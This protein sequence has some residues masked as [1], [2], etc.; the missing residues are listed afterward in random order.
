MIITCEACSTKFNLDESLLKPSGSKVRCSKCKTVFTAYPPEPEE[1]QVL[2]EVE[3]DPE[4]TSDDD[5]DFSDLEQ[6]LGSD[7]SSSDDLEPRD[8]SGIETTEIDDDIDEEID[9]PGLEDML[10]S[11]EDYQAPSDGDQDLELSFDSDEEEAVSE[12]DD[13]DISFD[14]D[15]SVETDELE[16]E[17]D[18]DDDLALSMDSDDAGEEE[19]VDDDL[20]DLS[21]SLDDADEEAEFID[22]ELEDFD[23]DLSLEPDDADEAEVADITDEELEDFDLD[24]SLEP[25]DTDEAEVADV[26]D[27]SL[28]DLDLDL[29]GV[30]AE[31]TLESDLLSTKTVSEIENDSDDLDFELDIDED[32]DDEDVEEID[33]AELEQTL[34]MEL[35]SPVDDDDSGGEP[36][37][38]DLELADDEDI[39]EDIDEE[40][41]MADDADVSDIEQMLE[42]DLDEEPDGNADEIEL[43]F[44]IDGEETEKEPA[45]ASAGDHDD[46]QSS[47]KTVAEAKPDKT[48]L[49]SGLDTKP[50]VKKKLST[51]LVILIVLL[52][53]GVAA[54]GGYFLLI[55][56]GVKLPSLQELNIPYISDL[57]NPD[58]KKDLG[59]V[60]A[61]QSTVKSEFYDNS[62]LGKLFVITGKV[63]NNTSKA[64]HSV[65][66][67]A[68]L[69][70]TGKKLAKSKTVYAGTKISKE[71][72][73]SSDLDSL[74]K[75]MASQNSVTGQ[76]IRIK[77]GEEISFMIVIPNLPVNLEEYKVMVTES[78]ME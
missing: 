67:T 16:E 20:D 25:D 15:D 78:T 4:I 61:T 31:G 17:V 40:L 37:N 9:I 39:S 66:V 27:D 56:Q 57:L 21:L 74:N 11:D 50:A 36:V 68:K 14:T 38:E 77:A 22:E 58:A 63:K 42:M 72:L 18:A 62:K 64:C 75:L 41:D 13:L 70:A 33:L 65:K 46:V 6:M 10:D 28:E 35:L 23:L 1:E 76:P 48:E 19:A 3:Q 49:S 53:L 43:E 54:V 12:D 45:L 8:E 55:S 7:D 59:M 47:I 5:L 30:D 2:P 73:S 44:D 51:P 34:E 32:S 60:E 29:E 26:T 69:Y 71:D 24:L 52:L